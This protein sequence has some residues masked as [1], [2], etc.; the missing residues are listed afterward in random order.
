MQTLQGEP[1]AYYKLGIPGFFLS[2][3][4]YFR[5]CKYCAVALCRNGLKGL[6][7]VRRLCDPR[8]CSL[9]FKESDIEISIFGRKSVRSDSYPTI[10]DPTKST[11][12][13]SSCSK[14]F[15]DRNTQCDEQPQ[16]KK[17]CPKKLNFEESIEICM[18]LRCD[19]SKP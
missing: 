15:A 1:C 6:M 14:R 10:F 9:H 13:V 7:S 11:N 17:D 5:L 18:D 19:F 3:A 8:I 16:A 4:V 2:F 12:T